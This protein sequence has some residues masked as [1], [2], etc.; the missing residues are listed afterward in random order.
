[1][2]QGRDI[3]YTHFEKTERLFLEYIFDMASKLPAALGASPYLAGSH[4]CSEDSAHRVSPLVRLRWK[5]K[6]GPF[7]AKF[8]NLQKLI[9]LPPN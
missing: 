3:V 2:S 9:I 1:M 8:N 7:P 6:L 4:G 5:T